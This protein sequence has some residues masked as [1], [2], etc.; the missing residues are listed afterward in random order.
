[1][2]NDTASD[3]R[4]AMALLK[5]GDVLFAAGLLACNLYLVRREKFNLACL[6]AVNDTDGLI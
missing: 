5:K 6:A 1:M 2:F 4:G 3:F